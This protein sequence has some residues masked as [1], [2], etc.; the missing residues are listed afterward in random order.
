MNMAGKTQPDAPRI[1]ISYSRKDAAVMRQLEARLKA[2]GAEVWVDHAGIRSGDNLPKRISDALEWCNVLLL[3]WSASSKASKWVEDEWTNAHSLG[4][5]I[6]PCV[7]DGVP[8]PGILASKVYV[9]FRR[10]E[11][12]IDE[13]LQSLGFSQPPAPPRQPRL[14]HGR[15]TDE[16]TSIKPPPPPALPILQLRSQPQINF[17]S[18]DVQKM[19][20]ERGFYDAYK[21]ENGKG[22][23][24]E[25]DAIERQGQKLVVDQATG[26]TWQKS[27]SEKYMTFAEAEEYIRELKR[28]KYAG[29]D[30]WRLP[31]LEE[32][33]SLMEPTKKNG[34]LYIDPIF[35]KTHRYIWT[36]DK[37]TAGV[38]WVV[39][40]YAGLC[41]SR[42]LSSYHYVRAVR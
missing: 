3:L 10:L 30:D 5:R 27:G 32:A 36:A 38:A 9:D 17:S 37:S 22:A 6:I 2:V 35:D 34:D 39:L 18:D 40:F 14:D 41:A 4:R 26:L 21:N 28:E 16:V 7:L 24:H 11:E 12:G 13:L 15:L 8:R 19:I 1:F 23:R 20:K 25:Y 31:T 29:H 33:M 42:G